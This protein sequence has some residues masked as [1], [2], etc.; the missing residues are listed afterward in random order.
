[1]ETDKVRVL[2]PSTDTGTGLVNS[3]AERA[4]LPVL[5]L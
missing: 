1:M 4:A 3:T 2:V 5:F